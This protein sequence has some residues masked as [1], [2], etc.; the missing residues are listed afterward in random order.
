MPVAPS[1]D[2]RSTLSPSIGSRASIPRQ[3][4]TALIVDDACLEEISLLFQIDHLAHPGERV[5]LVREKLRQADLRCAAVRDVAQIT[6]EH[7][8][9]HP[10]HPAWHRV[11]GIAVLEGDRFLEQ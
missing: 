10:Q 11:L 1:S 6:L 2:E 5:L 3:R 7:R 4:T 9:I 8:G